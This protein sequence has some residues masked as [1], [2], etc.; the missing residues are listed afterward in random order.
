M[1]EKVRKGIVLGVLVATLVWGYFHFFGSNKS[2]TN[3]RPQLQ[4]NYTHEETTP[5]AAP[6]QLPPELIESYR[7]KNWGPDPFYHNYRVGKT[8]SA[9]E[10]VHL[11][12][13][14]IVFRDF[15]AQALINGK[16][17]HEGDTL[18]DYRISTIARDHVILQH[19]NKTV[20]LWVTDKKS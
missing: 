7:R 4:Q 9:A 8:E 15:N 20:T 5:D 17:L 13:L 19:G 1:N 12:L 18:H 2:I 16:I 14:G 11:K 6:S 10:E 3:P